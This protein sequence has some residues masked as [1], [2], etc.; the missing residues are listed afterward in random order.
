MRLT[1]DDRPRT[2]RSRLGDYLVVQAIRLC[3][4]AMLVDPSRVSIQIDVAMPEREPVP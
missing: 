4:A 3:W 2:F 1:A